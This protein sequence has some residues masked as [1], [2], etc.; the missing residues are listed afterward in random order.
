M[1]GRVVMSPKVTI[2]ICDYGISVHRS[3]PLGG[4]DGSE[5]DEIVLERFLAV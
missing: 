1:A 4:R 3:V 2:A 5:Q